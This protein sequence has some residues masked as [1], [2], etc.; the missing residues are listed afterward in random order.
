MSHIC[1][2]AVTTALDRYFSWHWMDGVACQFFLSFVAHVLTIIKPPKIAGSWHVADSL[3]DKSV[4][5]A[6]GAVCTRS[7]AATVEHEQGNKCSTRSGQQLFNTVVLLSSQKNSKAVNMLHLSVAGICHLCPA[8]K[9]QPHLVS[10]PTDVCAQ[11]PWFRA[12]R[13]TCRFSL[14]VQPCTN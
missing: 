8:F 1:I 10:F 13:C 6:A 9:S 5:A 14:H 7:R 11:S 2:V 12:V 3:Q 4:V